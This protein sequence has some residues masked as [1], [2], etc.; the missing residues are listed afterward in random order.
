MVLVQGSIKIRSAFSD[1][2]LSSKGLCDRAIDVRQ[3]CRFGCTFCYVPSTSRIRCQTPQ[4]KAAGVTDPQQNWGDYAFDKEGLV[5]VLKTQLKSK[6]KLPSTPAGKGVFFLCSGTDPYQDL[7]TAK[8]TRHCVEALL[9]ANKRVRILTRSPLWVRDLDLLC[10]P[11]VTVG[12]SL[13]HSNDRLSRQIEKNAPSP[14]SR[15]K[16]LRKGKEKGCRIFVA[17]AP[18]PP[19]S[20][21]SEGELKAHL[22]VLAD[23]DPEVIFW[24]PINPRG[25]NTKRMLSAGLDWAA[26]LRSEVWASEFM[27]QWESIESEGDRIGILPKI[28]FWPDKNLLRYATESQKTKIFSWI[29][30]P[31]VELWPECQ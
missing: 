18:T 27:R 5:E 30:R 19:L 20:V 26:D 15:I 16:A 4:I 17:M 22:Q 24:E 1:S 21:I 10:N 2:T 12:A 25:S 7:D 3:G 11:N 9:E 6:R 28:H 14:S 13:P 29:D 23:L 31:T 8:T